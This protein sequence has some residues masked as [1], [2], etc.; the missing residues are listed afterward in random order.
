VNTVH[1]GLAV[2]CLLF[3]EQSYYGYQRAFISQ[4]TWKEIGTLKVNELTSYLPGSLTKHTV[5]QL[6]V[7]LI[8]F[9]VFI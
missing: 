4:E 5:T 6:T 1:R 8:R 3:E 2:M 7:Q 9:I